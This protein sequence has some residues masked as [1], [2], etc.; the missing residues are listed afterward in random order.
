[1]PCGAQS[2][3]RCPASL[4]RILRACDDLRLA[5][6]RLAFL[7]ES[8]AVSLLRLSRQEEWRKDAWIR[9]PC[10]SRVVLV[11]RAWL[12]PRG[13][14]TARRPAA[15]RTAAGLGLT[16]S[17]RCGF[18]AARRST[19]TS[20]RSASISASLGEEDRASNAS[21]DI[22]ITS[23]RYTSITHTSDDHVGAEIPGQA[24]SRVL[25]QHRRAGSPTPWMRRS[26]IRLGPV[27]L[28]FDYG[29]R[30]GF[31][32]PRTIS[33]LTETPVD[34]RPG[35]RRSVK[36]HLRA[37]KRRCQRRIVAG[38]TGK[39][40]A[41]RRR[42]TRRDNAASQSRLARSHRRRPLS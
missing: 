23:S 42:F 29:P 6:L 40:S 7:T 1:M 4:S 37:T 19:A 31:L 41:H 5:G 32:A 12:A 10:S 18:G 22:T 21:Q 36:V 17:D 13:A 26:H 11:D 33:V 30:P 8:S 15:D 2:R 20:C 14:G 24:D 27:R 34:G 38:A 9:A 28:G 3:V 35:R 39:I 16:Q 25:D